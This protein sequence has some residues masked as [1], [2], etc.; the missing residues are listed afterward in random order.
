[1]CSALDVS[2]FAA[3]S[4]YALAQLSSH[5]ENRD[6][7]SRNSSIGFLCRVIGRAKGRGNVDGE[8]IAVLRPNKLPAAG[9]FR[10]T[11][12]ISSYVIMT[13]EE[14]EGEN[15]FLYALV[16]ISPRR[17]PDLCVVVVVIVIDGIR[18]IVCY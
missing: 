4:D 8:S 12:V 15:E 11:I 2:R 9:S 13:K 3:L 18:E 1:M 16:R 17:N 5:R 7:V 14:D 6:P 10:S